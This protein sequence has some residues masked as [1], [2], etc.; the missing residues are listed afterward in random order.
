MHKL[1]DGEYKLMTIVWGNEPLSSKK[2]TV[3]C[4]KNLGWKRTTT[5]T[6]LKKLITKGFVENE[7]TIVSSVVV[8]KDVQKYESKEIVN[9]RFD[10]S[11][12]G[13][14]TA[15]TSNKKLSEVEVEELQNLINTY[16]GDD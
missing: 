7:S 13:F 12:M 9:E 4:E 3:I 10:G 16:K 11:L 5:Y 15:F 2:L 14:I 1:Y 8:K 6:V